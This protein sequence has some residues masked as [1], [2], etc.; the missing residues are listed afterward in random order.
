MA[1][2]WT[3][4]EELEEELRLERVAAVEAVIKP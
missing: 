2:K 3:R 1:H 4:I